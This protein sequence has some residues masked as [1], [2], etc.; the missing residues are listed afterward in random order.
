MD[1]A[2]FFKLYGSIISFFISVMGLVLSIISIYMIYRWRT[3][4][5]VDCINLIFPEKVEEKLLFRLYNNMNRDIHITCFEV[6]VRKGN[7]RFI[8]Q[9][10]L[11]NEESEFNK[12]HEI[13]FPPVITIKANSYKLIELKN[14]GLFK[15]KHGTKTRMFYHTKGSF[16][17]LHFINKKKESIRYA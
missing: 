1:I 14:D 15:G 3:P 7:K 5:M 11:S 17:I 2:L 4:I 13:G 12:S 9:Y 6:E 8:Y 16:L 10:I